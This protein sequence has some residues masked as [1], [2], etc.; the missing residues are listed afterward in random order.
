MGLM[1]LR[2]ALLILGCAAACPAFGDEG[3]VDGIRRVITA[4]FQAFADDDADAAFETATPRVRSSMG[5]PGRFLAMVRGHYPMVYRPASYAFL[6][7][8]LKARQ[9][10]QLVRVS[11]LHG[12]AWV[13]LFHLERQPDGSWRIG[14]CTVNEMRWQPT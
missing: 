4:Q 6:D 5:H 10:W 7:V 11:D 14:G 8:E 1:P 3:D 2:R 12:K 13:A 9:A